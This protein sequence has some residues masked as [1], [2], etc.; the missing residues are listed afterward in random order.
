MSNIG[1]LRER[2]RTTATPPPDAD[3]GDDGPGMQ[4]LKESAIGEMSVRTISELWSKESGQ[5]ASVIQT[6]LLSLFPEI[7]GET[8]HAVT[9]HSTISRD[10]FLKYCDTQKIPVPRF[11]A[12]TA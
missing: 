9:Q 12:N 3:A 11:W 2:V 1:Q 5:R 6:E 4:P 7:V 8:S 10:H